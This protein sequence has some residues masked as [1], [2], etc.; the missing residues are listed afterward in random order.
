VRRY[1]IQ[2][3]KVYDLSAMTYSGMQIHP[4]EE[5]AGAR[6]LVERH[7]MPEG[8]P[9]AIHHD[10]LHLGF[11]VEFEEL[12]QG[13]ALIGLHDAT[14]LRPGG[15]LTT[16]IPRQSLRLSEGNTHTRRT[17]SANTAIFLQTPDN[18]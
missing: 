12:L 7:D 9:L 2:F 5:A 17:A 3:E 10:R 15:I 18:T 13:L 16:D 4:A 14:S 11:G 1:T 8:V 6:A